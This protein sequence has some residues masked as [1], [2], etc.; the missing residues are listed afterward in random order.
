MLVLLYLVAAYFI[1]QNFRQSFNFLKL[2]RN[3]IS[4]STTCGIE[5]TV[6]ANKH[7]STNQ[8]KNYLF[9][10]LIYWPIDLIIGLYLSSTY[11][12][13]VH[14]LLVRVTNIIPSIPS[15]IIVNSLLLLLT[16]SLI[17]HY[18]NARKTASASTVK[19]HSKIEAN[20]YLFSNNKKL[21][22]I[23]NKKLVAII[24]L[25]AI[26]LAW[27][28]FLTQRS[29]Q[30]NGS[31]LAAG[32]T[33]FSD[34]APHTA[35]VRNFAFGNIPSSYPH[36]AGAGMNYHFFFY[37]LCGLLNAL[38]LRLDWSINFPSILGIVAFMQTLFYVS[39]LLTSKLSAGFLS[40]LFFCFRSSF[41]GFFVFFAELRESN[42]LWLAIKNLWKSNSYSGPLLHDDWGLY[43]LNVY[44]NQRHLLF[45]LSI[46]VWVLLTFY[47]SLKNKVINKVTWAEIIGLSLLGLPMAY[48]H[49]SVLIT[50]NLILIV[51]ALFT[52]SKTQYLIFGITNVF[53]ALV[54][55]KIFT[56]A[57]TNSNSMF[58]NIFHF[59][60]IL[61]N[62]SILNISQFLITLYGIALVFIL[63]APFIHKEKSLKIVSASLVL[64]IV[65]ALTISLTP[66]TT[67]NHKFFIFTQ[68]LFIPFISYFIVNLWTYVKVKT[69]ENQGNIYK[70]TATRSAKAKFT[71]FLCKTVC[72]I[73]IFVMTFTGIIDFAVYKNASLNR[74]EIQTA[75]DFSQWIYQHTAANSINL[76]PPWHYHSYF[77]TGR[78]AYFGWPYYSQSA[79]YDVQTREQEIKRIL[80]A[81]VNDY[82][83]N[84]DYLQKNNINYLM[85]DD[86]WRNYEDV[87][88]NEDQ[89]AQ[90]FPE[91]AYFPEQNNLRIYKVS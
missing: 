81:E 21:V 85:I 90:W 67:V 78:M 23:N 64:P 86:F 55:L 47:P 41:S 66:D 53:G 63:C 20:P 34:L 83:K 11:N 45:V 3:I 87:F 79:G 17:N 5:Q 60:Y 40:L 27:G 76:T 77:T 29:F 44:A 14:L 22:L 6:D 31:T 82:Q 89:L 35:N 18:K 16:T 59:G 42:N 61:E 56:K 71:N 1:G 25:Q 37:Y 7:F 26:S 32:A 33:V 91:V 9:K 39:L 75:D 70:K 46:A 15:L 52:K 88:I 28:I 74:V 73:G 51:W 10:L 62:P 84:K 54:M 68:I 19:A 72:I 43:N 24:C 65:F 12:Y 69:S 48:W 49:G 36:F 30:L 8:L 4:N 2:Y 57:G 38:G 80:L 58:K 50:L 13:F